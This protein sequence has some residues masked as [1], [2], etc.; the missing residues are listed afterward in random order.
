MYNNVKKK[1][2]PQRCT[3]C[4]VQYQQREPRSK[5]RVL[6][7]GGLMEDIVPQQRFLYKN[8]LENKLTHLKVRGKVLRRPH[9]GTL[10][11]NA[12]G[13][14]P[15]SIIRKRWFPQGADKESIDKLA[16]QLVAYTENHTGFL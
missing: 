7:G 4:R 14:M 10:I 8:P 2:E 11:P 12:L 1:V 15:K 5:T 16:V 6:T 13:F 3:V 9:C